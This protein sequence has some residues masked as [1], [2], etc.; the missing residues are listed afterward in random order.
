[1]SHHIVAIAIERVLPS[2]PI[3]K[4]TT[5]GAW[6]MFANI[7]AVKSEHR[8]IWYCP[9][10]G[11]KKDWNLT[12]KLHSTGNLLYHKY[13]ALEAKILS[14]NCLVHSRDNFSQNATWRTPINRKK[15]GT[16]RFKLD[17]NIPQRV[18]FCLPSVLERPIEM[19]PEAINTN[20]N[21]YHRKNSG[22]WNG[23]GQNVSCE[24][25]TGPI[26]I[27]SCRRAGKSR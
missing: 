9:L 23:D 25:W 16:E 4:G 7:L 20:A 3:N 1:M 24:Y 19:D 17:S 10:V 13:Q 18:R 12:D 5:F 6:P 21:A 14:I 22:Y 8:V 15:K 2:L 26:L 11:D 27:W